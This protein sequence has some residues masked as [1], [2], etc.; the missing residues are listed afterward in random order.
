M[1]S[2]AHKH[3]L[4]AFREANDL[5]QTEAA[6][7]VGIT[8]A[9][10]SRLEKETA[11]ASPSVAKRIADLTGMALERL[12]N[13]GDSDSVGVLDVPPVDQP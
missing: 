3:P 10:W 13:F 11:F 5:S 6:A 7:L 9:M 12:L 2:R 4:V 1:M 8:Q